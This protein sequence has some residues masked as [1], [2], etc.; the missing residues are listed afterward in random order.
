MTLQAS[1]DAMRDDAGKWRGVAGVLKKAQNDA[2]PLTLTTKDLSFAADD[3]GMLLAYNEIKAK[4]ERLLGEGNE[5]LDKLA[6]RLYEVA[7]E[8]QRSDENASKKFQGVWDPKR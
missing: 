7:D 6:T 5:I 4:A 1:I 3:T 8:Y 2:V